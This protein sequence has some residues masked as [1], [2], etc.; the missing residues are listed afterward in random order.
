MKS[1]PKLI[2]GESSP[3]KK[4]IFQKEDNLKK[5]LSRGEKAIIEDSE[6]DED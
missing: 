3:K 2:K 5:Q 4:S 1:S 6:L